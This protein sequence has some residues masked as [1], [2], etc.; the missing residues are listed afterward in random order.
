[1]ARKVILS[2]LIQQDFEDEDVM[3][4]VA[5]LGDDE[6]VGTQVFPDTL[7]VAAKQ[8]DK[9]R[10]QYDDQLRRYLIY[11]LVTSHRLP[12]MGNRNLEINDPLNFLSEVIGETPAG[13]IPEKVRNCFVRYPRHVVSLEFIFTTALHQIKNEFFVLEQ[14]CA[15]QGYVYTFNPPMIFA[16]ALGSKGTEFISRIHVAALKHFMST[17]ELKGC[18]CIAWD[19][20]GSQTI[21]SLL[22]QA[23][24]GRPEIIVMRRIDVFPPNRSVNNGPKGL[25]VPPEGAENALVVIHNNSDGF[26]QNIETEWSGG[27][28][29]GVIGYYSSAAGSLM[30]YRKDLCD[31]LVQTEK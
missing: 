22:R 14:I 5:M 6:V 25:Y 23:L 31:R 26:G 17:V 20:F 21:L 19:D 15:S 11:H 2:A 27:S 9:K 30:R 28:L 12:A 18:K 29:D 8:D 13:S 3:M 10:A 7:D 16:R 4:K 1:L 24:S